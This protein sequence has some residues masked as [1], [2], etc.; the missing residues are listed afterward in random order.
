MGLKTKNLAP[1]S[2]KEYLESNGSTMETFYNKLDMGQL[3][4][5]YCMLSNISET[6]IY[7]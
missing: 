5:C 1:V 3:L 6:V 7:E 2:E 4:L